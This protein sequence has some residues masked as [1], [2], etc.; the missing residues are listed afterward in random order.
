[1]I[2]EGCMHGWLERKLSILGQVCSWS[3]PKP[4]VTLI[5]YIATVPSSV[6][7]EKTREKAFKAAV[8]FIKS[9][10]REHGWNIEEE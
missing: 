9:V 6:I 1:M 5:L 7:D 2:F 4:A 3:D 8:E 10:Q